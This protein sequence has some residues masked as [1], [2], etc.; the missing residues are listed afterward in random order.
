MGLGVLIIG[1]PLLGFL[2]QLMQKN[3]VQKM[4]KVRLNE[5][6]PHSNEAELDD[7]FPG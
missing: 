2:A 3:Q 5:L 7:P 1:S 4:E 6:I